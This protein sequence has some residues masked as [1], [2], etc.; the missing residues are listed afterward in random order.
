[1]QVGGGS[2]DQSVFVGGECVD[3]CGSLEQPFV[4]AVAHFLD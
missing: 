2:G 1:M 4:H 3:G